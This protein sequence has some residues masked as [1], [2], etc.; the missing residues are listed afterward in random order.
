LADRIIQVQ[1]TC[2]VFAL[3]RV[4]D[5]WGNAPQVALRLSDGNVNGGIRDVKKERSLPTLRKPPD[6]LGREEVGDM[7]R[8]LDERAVP[9]PGLRELP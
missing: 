2:Q 4:G 8:F 5:L 3:T 1:D 9:L 6:R 7:P